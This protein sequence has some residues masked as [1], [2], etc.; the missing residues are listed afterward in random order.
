MLHL[1]GMQLYRKM[2]DVVEYDPEGSSDQP[3]H[4]EPDADVETDDEADIT[5]E[6]TADRQGVVLS[7]NNGAAVTRGVNA[8]TL[9]VLQTVEDIDQVIQAVKDKRQRFVPRVK[10]ALA[11]P[12]SPFC[13]HMLDDKERAD[14]AAAVAENHGKHEEDVLKRYKVHVTAGENPTRSVELAMQLYDRL[15]ERDITE[16]RDKEN[17]LH[18]KQQLYVQW[19]QHNE[20]LAHKSQMQAAELKHEAKL[21]R[22][23]MAVEQARHAADVAAQAQERVRQQFESIVLCIGGNIMVCVLSFSVFF[24]NYFG[25]RFSRLNIKLSPKSTPAVS[26]ESTPAD[27]NN[28]PAPKERSRFSWLRWPRWLSTESVTKSIATNLGDIILYP[29]Q[30]AWSFITHVFERMG[31]IVA[32]ALL[33][34][35]DFAAFLLVFFLFETAHTLIMFV[36]ATAIGVAADVIYHL[37]SGGEHLPFDGAWFCEN[38]YRLSGLDRLSDVALT[39]ALFGV[40]FVASFFVF[41]AFGW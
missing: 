3:G 1:A 10:H 27:S 18:A 37:A 4:Q 29:F 17:R 7:S 31:M 38:L 2:K 39:L 5:G 26:P 35:L 34:V 19:I 36:V 23:Q 21:L 11:Q 12:S 13:Y 22:E 16:L 14:L 9:G 20:S 40:N 8:A 30:K 15:V 33:V 24:G 32:G 25:M 28:V 6:D 41:R